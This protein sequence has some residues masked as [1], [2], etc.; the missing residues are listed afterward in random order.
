[1]L[2]CDP[3]DLYMVSWRLRHGIEPELNRQ[4]QRVAETEAM[5]FECSTTRV[6]TKSANISRSRPSNS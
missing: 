2:R 4:V 3:A 1:M 5:R 6:Q